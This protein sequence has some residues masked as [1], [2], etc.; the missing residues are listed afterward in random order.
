V[1]CEKLSELGL[2]KT[3][4]SKNIQNKNIQIF[5][6]KVITKKKNEFF[7][8]SVPLFILAYHTSEKT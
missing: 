6:K 1:G 7:S 4:F 5:S 3:Y 2:I 8:Y